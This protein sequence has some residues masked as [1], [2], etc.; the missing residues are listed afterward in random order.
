[1]YVLLFLFVLCFLFLF[2]FVFCFVLFF[3]YFCFILSYLYI[4]VLYGNYVTHYCG[5]EDNRYCNY[6]LET[7]KLSTEECW[8]RGSGRQ[9][10]YSGPIE[11]HTFGAPNG[12][13][14]SFVY[15]C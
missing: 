1:M 14:V 10:V 2:R 13:V 5:F 7:C 4:T 8:Y 3:H 6:T 9:D 15:V 12:M 11:D